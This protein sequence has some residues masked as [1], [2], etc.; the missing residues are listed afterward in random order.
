MYVYI[1]PAVNIVIT[2]KGVTVPDIII[3]LIWCLETED[4]R[5][6]WMEKK[7]LNVMFNNY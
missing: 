2:N 4:E 5:R 1:H 3:F 7:L 6:G